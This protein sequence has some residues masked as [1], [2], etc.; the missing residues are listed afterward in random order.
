MQILSRFNL[1]LFSCGHATIRGFVRPSVR[2]SVGLSA[3]VKNWDKAH[4]RPCSPV[5]NWWPCIRPCYFLYWRLQNPT[6]N[7]LHSLV[8]QNPMWHYFYVSLLFIFP[9]VNDVWVTSWA[10]STHSTIHNIQ[11][12]FIQPSA[13]ARRLESNITSRNS[14]W[15]QQHL[16]NNSSWRLHKLHFTSPSSR[17]LH[18]IVNQWVTTAPKSTLGTFPQPHHSNASSTAS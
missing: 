8:A 16:D 9:H 4:F 13:A 14:S 2:P 7:R 18:D 3:R 6:H 5:H 11:V 10:S 1:F 15:Q 12:D 17:G